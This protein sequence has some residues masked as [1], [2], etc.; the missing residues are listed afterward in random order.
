MSLLSFLLSYLFY[1]RDDAPEYF[2][3]HHNVT[4]GGG[5]GGQNNLL[6]LIGL[7]ENQLWNVLKVQ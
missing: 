4:E 2:S 6:S 1:P 5:E 3:V 7:S